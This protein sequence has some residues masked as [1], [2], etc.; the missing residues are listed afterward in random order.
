MLK[1]TKTLAVSALLASAVCSS[2]AFAEPGAA[3]E[4]NGEAPRAAPMDDLDIGRAKPIAPPKLKEDETSRAAPT[5]EDAAVKS[6]GIV[7]RSSAGKDVV[8]E[9][10]ETMRKIILEELNAPA[11]GDKKAEGTSGPAIGIDPALG[12]GEEANRQVFGDDDRVQIKNTKVYPFTAI[13]YL[14][15]KTKGGAFGSCSATLIGPRTVLTAAHCLYNHDDGGWLDEFIFVPSLNGSTADDAPYGA[16]DY[17]TAY[18]VQG[19]I[20]NY[21]GFYGSVVPWDLGVITLKEPVGDNL[22]WLGYANYDNLGD[23][24]ANIVGYPGDKPMGTMW[25]ATCNVVAEQ[26]DEINFQYD[27]D[28]YPGS[29]GSSVYA[30]DNAVKQRIV[31]GVN[32]AESPSANTAVRLNKTYVEWINSLWK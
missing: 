16:F 9:P 14:E 24:D 13:G 3:N 6:F 28:T 26:I 17:D 10:S 5:D 32:V 21:Q 30:Y 11:P 23:F 31:V 19:Y 8:V 22:G 29:S 15:G 1:L 20:D 2:S 12:E 7:G 4:G 18:I 25:R 27:C